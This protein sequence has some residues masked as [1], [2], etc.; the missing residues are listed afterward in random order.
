ME[1]KDEV[2]VCRCG[3]KH[4]LIDS[5]EISCANCGNI[6]RFIGE[7]AHDFNIARRVA[8]A[9]QERLDLG[10]GNNAKLL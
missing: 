4:W 9:N 7:S 5:G 6:Y 2:Y 3:N 8:D 1:D 10:E